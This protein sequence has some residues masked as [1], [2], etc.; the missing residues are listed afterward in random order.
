MHKLFTLV[1]VGLLFLFG[2]ASSSTIP[3]HDLEATVEYD[4][5]TTRAV[6]SFPARDPD[7]THT[8]GDDSCG[9]TSG[10]CGSDAPTYAAVHGDGTPIA[11]A[12]FT[13]L[14]TGDAG[15]Y[16]I[17]ITRTPA[18]EAAYQAMSK[19]HG[20]V[21]PETAILCRVYDTEIGTPQ[22]CF[23]SSRSVHITL[24]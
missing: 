18:D 20:Y 12:L 14:H 7:A 15:I 23:Y 5:T 3:A 16:D 13:T 6:L 1:P 19:G 22:M 17:A 21:V 2:C 8:S 10:N 4:G 9:F 11:R 24:R